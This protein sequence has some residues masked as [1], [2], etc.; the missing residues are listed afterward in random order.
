MSGNLG[1]KSQQ[2]FLLS[3]KSTRKYPK[4]IS[5][6]KE[7]YKKSKKPDFSKKLPNRIKSV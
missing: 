5:I 4:S 1:S 3:P 7:I 2:N 6:Y